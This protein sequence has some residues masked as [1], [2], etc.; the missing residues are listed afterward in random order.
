MLPDYPEIKSKISTI[1]QKR[2]NKIISNTPFDGNTHHL[3]EGHESI[4][5]YQN[6][7][8]EN[9]PFQSVETKVNLDIEDLNS[10]SISDVINHIDSISSNLALQKSKYTLKVVEE[11]LKGTK[12]YK[13]SK[14]LTPETLLEAW[15]NIQ[16]EFYSNGEPIIP[17]LFVHPD[18]KRDSEEIV[19]LIENTPELINRRKK[20]IDK[21]RENWRDRESNRKLVG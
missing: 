16:M 14:G 9:I 8:I 21:Q 12:N 18:K 3:F 1:L 7:T 19:S 10:L 4:I 11:K 15:E 2:M 17:K 20:I 6:G 5:I 13:K